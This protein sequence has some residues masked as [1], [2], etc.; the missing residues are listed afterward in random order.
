MVNRLT[1]ILM[2]WVLSLGVASAE[3]VEVSVSDASPYSQQTIIFTV[4]VTGDRYLDKFSVTLPSINDTII[5]K[6]D[7]SP[8]SYTQM[9]KKSRQYISEY[10]YAVTVLAEK[11]NIQIPSVTVNA[12]RADVKDRYGRLL[13]YG[14]RFYPKSQPITL[15][16]R[17]AKR[18]SAEPWLPLHGLQVSAKLLDEPPLKLGLPARYKVTIRANG[19]L[20]QDIPSMLA[21]VPESAFKMYVEQT[22][23]EDKISSNGTTIEGFRE[24]IITLVPQTV[25]KLELPNKAIDWW[26]VRF[27]KPGRAEMLSY[28]VVVQGEA[29]EAVSEVEKNREVTDFSETLKV[30]AMMVSGAILF[31]AGIWFGAGRP[32]SRA[33]QRRFDKM[34]IFIHRR[35]DSVVNPVS[36][37][38]GRLSSRFNWGQKEK[39]KHWHPKPFK[40]WLTTAELRLEKR[41]PVRWRTK[42]FFKR[43][44]LERD[45]KILSSMLS[46]YASECLKMP[47][48][49]PLRNIGVRLSLHFPQ[50]SSDRINNTFTELENALYGHADFNAKH[51]HQHFYKVFKHKSMRSACVLDEPA[52]LTLPEL[53]PNHN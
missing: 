47:S 43:L 34:M 17:P 52:I 26:D 53:N 13:R 51:W 50:V 24:E 19:A 7:V 40:Y 28:Q 1:L 8:H 10:R 38:I 4:R 48:N 31:I 37:W 11:G 22:K 16:V 9:G 6:V 15:V 2:S 14:Q 49:T 21:L 5:K 3:V 39:T 12:K 44:A 18:V 30:M 33:V 29:D 20:A 42:R 46:E 36:F 32:S 41:L 35:V 45:P 27:D 25:G 23:L